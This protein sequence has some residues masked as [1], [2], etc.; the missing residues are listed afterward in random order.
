V[1]NENQRVECKLSKMNVV[2][3]KIV[4]SVW[5]VCFIV[6]GIGSVGV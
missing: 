1:W 3:H 5:K 6:N 2:K 4:Y